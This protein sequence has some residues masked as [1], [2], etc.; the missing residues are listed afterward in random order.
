[1]YECNR[2]FDPFKR[3]KYKE[4]TASTVCRISVEKQISN[5]TYTYGTQYRE[6]VKEVAEMIPTDLDDP[7]KLKWIADYLLENVEVYQIQDSQDIEEIDV[8]DDK[9]IDPEKLLATGYGALLLHSA[10]ALQFYYN[11]GLCKVGQSRA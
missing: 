10:T 8:T 7:Q 6:S 9:E 4:N 11:A 5:W 3:Y 2:Q 1:M